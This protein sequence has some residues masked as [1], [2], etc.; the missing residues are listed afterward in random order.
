MDCVSICCRTRSSLP[1]RQHCDQAELHRDSIRW[2]SPLVLCSQVR[3]SNAE[4]L[5]PLQMI[6]RSGV[7]GVLVELGAVS[8]GTAQWRRAI[9]ALSRR[10]DKEG[11]GFKHF[12]YMGTSVALQKSLTQAIDLHAHELVARSTSHVTDPRDAA[13]KKL[14]EEEASP[15]TNTSATT[16][17]GKGDRTNAERT[18]ID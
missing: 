6:L 10:S 13:L 3:K 2:R 16:P 18:A 15:R 1:R 9:D 14:R 4:H 7:R 5:P 8:T 12:C 17:F 11:H